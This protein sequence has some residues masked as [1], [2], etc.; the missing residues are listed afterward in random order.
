M[1]SQQE[2]R[3]QAERNE[4]F[5]GRL[6]NPDEADW[7]CVVAF[8]AALHLLD[9]FLLRSLPQPKDHDERFD[10]LRRQRRPDLWKAYRA[11]WD[12]GHAAR[13]D[14]FGPLK[15][16]RSKSVQKLGTFKRE[17]AKA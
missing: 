11:L 12:D 7:C 9:A 1:A 16:D 5:L 4:A 17:V 10:F 8:Y 3:E 6:V 2:H 15:F 14:C 13:Y